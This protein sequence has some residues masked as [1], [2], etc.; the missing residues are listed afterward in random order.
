MVSNINRAIAERILSE[1]RIHNPNSGGVMV[2]IIGSK[3]CGKT[4]LLTRLSHQVV[5][6]HPT[7]QAV[8]RETVIWRGRTLDYWNWMYSSDF[9]WEAP[10]F[11]RKVYIHYHE[12]DSPTFVDEL[13]Q[14]IVFPPDALKTYRTARDLHENLELGEINVVYEPSRYRMTRGMRDI[15]T[16]RAC[17]SP[18]VL[19]DLEIDPPLWWVEFLFYLLQFKKAGFLTVILDEADEIFP[20]TSSGIRWHIQALFCDAAKDFRKANISLFYSIHDL[21]DLDYRLRSKTQYWGYMRGARPKPGSL[22]GRT[23]AL[24]LPIGEVIFERDGYGNTNLG[25]LQERPR[26][27]TLFLSGT[28]DPAAW[29]EYIDDEDTAPL[30]LSCP[31]CGHTWIPRVIAPRFCPNCK[32]ALEYEVGLENI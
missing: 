24:L 16:A 11:R 17:A 30:T 22:L 6:W 10:E 28:G 29:E 31:L 19:D 27:R 26:V 7:L 18:G 9:E 15:L 20:Q 4:H 32:A 23:A 21:T 2:A 3:G 25:K 12:E 14:D 1:I 5:F 13:G 8:M